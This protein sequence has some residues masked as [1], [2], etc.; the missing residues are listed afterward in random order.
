MKTQPFLIV[1]SQR[2]GGTF[3]AH[4]LSNHPQVF[5]DRGESLHGRGVWHRVTTMSNEQ[6]IEAMFSQQF[7]HASG[8]KL[9]WP[10]RDWDG[11]SLPI[12]QRMSP[13]IILLTREDKVRQAISILYLKAGKRAHPGFSVHS[14]NG[15]RPSF[16]VRIE[17]D[18]V[19]HWCGRLNGIAKVARRAIREA[20]LRCMEI[21]YEQMTGSADESAECIRPDVAQ[22][23]CEFL[24]VDDHPLCAGLRKLSPRDLSE[25]V[26]NWDEIRQAAGGAK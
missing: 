14:D 18:E 17:P 2:S 11:L 20:G 19:L 1:A 26:S 13:R 5:C 9:N 3:L 25:I 16:R 7:Y 24:N 12:I 23:L 4:A 6:I 21:T 15:E 22:Q 10:G 8:F